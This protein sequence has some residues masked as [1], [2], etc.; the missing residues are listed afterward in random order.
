METVSI[1]E[2]GKPLIVTGAIARLHRL[3]RS[4]HGNR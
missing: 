2:E 4:I 1:Q 3:V